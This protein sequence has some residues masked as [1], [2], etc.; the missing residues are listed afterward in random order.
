MTHENGEPDGQ[1]GGTQTPVTPLVGHGEDTNHQ[2][3]SEKHLDSGRHAQADA[4]LQLN[5]GRMRKT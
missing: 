2:L 1:S 4:R 3:Q 5:A